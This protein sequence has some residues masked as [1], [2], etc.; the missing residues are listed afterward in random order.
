MLS[1]SSFFFLLALCIFLRVH[2]E[3]VCRLAENERAPWF[4]PD[5]PP[6]AVGPTLS[7]GLCLQPSA[8]GFDLFKV[9]SVMW[10]T[11]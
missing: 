11:Q 2:L 3:A 8:V 6:A 4:I 5:A 7:T 9:P 10:A 1:L